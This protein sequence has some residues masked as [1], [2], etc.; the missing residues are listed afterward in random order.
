MEEVKSLHMEGPRSAARRAANERR[1][2]GMLAAMQ[3]QQTPPVHV[4]PGLPPP[5]AIESVSYTHLTLP[6]KRIV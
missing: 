5:P 3:R 6:T 2:L 1:A 4:S